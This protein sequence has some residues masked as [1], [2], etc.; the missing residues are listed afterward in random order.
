LALQITGYP[1][2]MKSMPVFPMHRTPVTAL[3]EFCR[4]ADSVVYFFEGMPVFSH[5]VMDIVT[6][7]MI[8]AEFCVNG[9]AEQEDIV[10]AFAVDA[11]GV[12]LAV[13]LYSTMGMAGFY[14]KHVPGWTKSRAAMGKRLDKSKVSKSR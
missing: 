8:T 5:H 6:F 12:E 10:R 7:H 9:H 11:E 4:H 3:L 14:P 13:E 2:T 1:I